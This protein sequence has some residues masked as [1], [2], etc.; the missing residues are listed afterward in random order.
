MFKRRANPCQWTRY[1]MVKLHCKYLYSFM[2][3]CNIFQVL[4]HL[5][6]MYLS[7]FLGMSKV[8]T[9]SPH[10]SR[11]QKKCGTC[12]SFLSKL[13]PHPECNKCLPEC[14]ARGSL[15]SLCPPLPGCMEEVGVPAVHKKSS[16]TMKGPKGESAKGG[17]SL[18]RYAQRFHLPPKLFLPVG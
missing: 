5:L 14:A 2:F 12:H 15:V 4:L 17:T 16:S 8:E 3:P 7:H 18:G 6:C 11:K 13:D 1:R 10:A 9:P